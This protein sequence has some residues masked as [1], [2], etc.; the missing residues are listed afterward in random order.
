MSACMLICR[1]I[2]SHWSVTKITCQFAFESAHWRIFSVEWSFNETNRFSNTPTKISTGI[3]FLD[4]LKEKCCEAVRNI[5]IMFDKFWR[6]IDHPRYNFGHFRTASQIW[7]SCQSPQP[8]P[9]CKPIRFRHVVKSGIIEN[10][11][12]HVLVSLPIDR[13]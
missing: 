1:G 12:S 6:S 7:P 5:L 4:N 8:A 2:Q 11:T 3:A 10:G 13:D 9:N